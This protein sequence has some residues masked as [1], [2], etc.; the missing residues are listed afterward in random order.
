[1]R[2]L[3]FAVLTAATCIGCSEENRSTTTTATKP[4]THGTTGERDATTVTTAKPQTETVTAAKPLSDATNVD[5]DNTAVNKRDRNSAAKT[6]ID[7]NENKKDIDVTA[8]IRKRVV[9][10][11]M[12]VNAHNVKIM[13]QD[14]KVTLRG[15][16]KSADE[17]KQIEDISRDVAG[18]DNVDS[19]LDVETKP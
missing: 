19:Q 16:V 3:A 7:Q 13:T 12:S 14:G 8:T 15:P 18:K 10:T 11:K 6:P 17:K 9:A 5:R 1:M 4:V 2:S